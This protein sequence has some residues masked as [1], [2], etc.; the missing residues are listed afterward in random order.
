MNI[1]K[2]KKE[3]LNIIGGLSK[4]YKMPGYG[5]SISALRCNRGSKMRSVE[6]S[7]CQKCYALKGR[8]IFKNTYIAMERRLSNLNDPKWIDAMTFVLKDE[9]YFRWFD[10]GDIQDFSHLLKIIE[11]CKNTPNCKHWLPTREFRFIKLYLEKFNNFPDNLCVRL[12]SD[13][14]DKRPVREFNG[15]GIS[16][17]SINNWTNTTEHPIAH[18][19][20]VDANKNIKTCQQAGC[21]ACWDKNVYHVNYKIH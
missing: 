8:Y 6:G 12:S 11:V 5:W 9:T 15:C 1:F 20:P 17:T 2:T 3:A 10:S 14:I 19:C 18:D 16:T 21:N 4:P 13:F 7:T